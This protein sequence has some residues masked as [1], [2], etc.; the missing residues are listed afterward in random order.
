MQR[1]IAIIGASSFIGQKIIA[2]NL[3]Y[4]FVPIV[5]APSGL[6]NEQVVSNYDDIPERILEGIETVVNCVGVVR[7]RNT[8]EYYRV[9]EV[10][11]YNIAQSLKPTGI[12]H[13]IHFSSLSIY[14]NIELATET[15]RPNPVS[16]YGKSKLAGDVALETLEDS[17]FKIAYIRPPVVYDEK[18]G[19]KI[20]VLANFMMRFRFFFCPIDL[21]ERA[22]I[23]VS[24]L[25]HYLNQIIENSFKGPA[26]IADNKTMSI[27]LIGD[28]IK[29]E[30]GSPVFIIKLPLTMFLPIKLIA[31]D[32]YNS[33]FRA[34]AVEVNV[35]KGKDYPKNDGE[36]G[37]REM[38]RGLHP[39]A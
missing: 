19:G 39:N 23:N 2:N 12:K 34:Q 37:L 35:A 1:K 33:V 20:A 31:V 15:S 9:N 32:A 22:I 13:F 26:L 29:D 36:V 7:G 5:R 10:L 3:N 27:K 30:F 6:S 4:D 18:N 16:L 21:P 8:D 25:N 14:G 17:E 11:V 24:V 28:I 38:I